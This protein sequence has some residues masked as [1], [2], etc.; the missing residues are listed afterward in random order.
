MERLPATA[1]AMGSL[2]RLAALFELTRAEEEAG[3][4]DSIATSIMLASPYDA[5]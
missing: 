5:I 1:D 2:Q 4:V 3:T